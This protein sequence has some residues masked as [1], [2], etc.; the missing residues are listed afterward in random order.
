MAF[1][2]WLK[3]IVWE[4]VDDTLIAGFFVVVFLASCAFLDYLASQANY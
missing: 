3:S 1:L 2:R 4:T